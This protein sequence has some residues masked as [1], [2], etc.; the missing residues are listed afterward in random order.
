MNFRFMTG[1]S[2]IKNQAIANPSF[3]GGRR[4][5]T[6]IHVM[7]A[8]R[9]IENNKDGL[10]KVSEMSI[11]RSAFKFMGRRIKLTYEEMV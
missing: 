11:R 2:V 4:Y 7:S 9:L 8:M 10:A 5:F 1:R 3:L 6:W